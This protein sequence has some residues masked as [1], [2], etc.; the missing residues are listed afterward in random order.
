[1]R[2]AKEMRR[3]G[4]VMCCAG[5]GCA[6][7]T[8]AAAPSSR[9]AKS[10]KEGGAGQT[11]AKKTFDIAF[12]GIYCSACEL[13]LKG[14]QG[15][16]K[17]KGCTHP[18][19]ESKCVIFA[20]AKEKKVANC[21]LCEQFESCEKLKQHHEKPLYRRVARRTCAKVKAD[22]MEATVAEQKTRWT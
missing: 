1:M 11:S 22:G 3:R 15:G 5:M 18:S 13:H 10:L 9:N 6:G 17:C 16:K 19:M 12:C 21:G 2:T 14:K 4:F 20:C 7:L 8:Q